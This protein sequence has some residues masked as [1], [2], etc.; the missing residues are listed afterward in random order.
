FGRH[1]YVASN[2]GVSDK[3]DAF[4]VSYNYILP[5]RTANFRQTF[6]LAFESPSGGASSSGEQ[7]IA[8][9]YQ[10]AYRVNN[11]ASILVLAK[12]TVGYNATASSAR[13]NELTLSPSALISLRA[14]TYAALTSEYHRYS[15]YRNDTT[16]DSILNV[17]R[18]FSGFNVR[19]YYGLPLGIYSY[20]H[21]FR[22]SYGLST[23]IQL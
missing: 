9:L 21:L 5:A 11:A 6:G 2:T 1:P 15:G 3:G 19:A 14:N 18:L 17:G 4:I 16:Y 10:L 7:Q 20:R 12:Y 8:P 22:S 23:S 13:Y